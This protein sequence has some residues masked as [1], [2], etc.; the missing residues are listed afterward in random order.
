MTCRVACLEEVV[1][2]ARTS[3]LLVAPVRHRPAEEARNDNEAHKDREH[4][5]DCGRVVISP[6][7]AVGYQVDALAEQG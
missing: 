7:Q 2:P 5:L 1:P 3:R 6:E 4:L